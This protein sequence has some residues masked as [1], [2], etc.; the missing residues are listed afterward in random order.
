VLTH[1]WPFAVG[2][3]VAL[4]VGAVVGVVLWVGAPVAAG[5][6]LGGFLARLCGAADA[7]C[8]GLGVSVLQSTNGIA[9]K[10]RN[11]IKGRRMRM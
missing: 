10:E 11:A 7:A 3:V 4:A 6:T 9:T 5:A 2:T 1:T 8:L